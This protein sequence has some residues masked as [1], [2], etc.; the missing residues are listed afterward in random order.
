M[1]LYRLMLEEHGDVFPASL[2][3]VQKAVSK[4][5][6]PE[7]GRLLP[8]CL[9]RGRAPPP[10]MPAS[11]CRHQ[12]PFA[13]RRAIHHDGILA[14]RGTDAQVRLGRS[15]ERLAGHRHEKGGRRHPGDQAEKEGWLARKGLQRPPDPSRDLYRRGTMLPQTLPFCLLDVSAL[16]LKTLEA[17]ARAVKAQ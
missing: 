13:R 6:V 14:N 12:R 7:S 4:L 2:E 3:A 5:A 8:Q 16:T 10:K 15:H 11:G 17:L 9:H 1:P